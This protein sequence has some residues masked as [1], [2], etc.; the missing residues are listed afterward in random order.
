MT[1]LVFI[2]NIRLNYKSPQIAWYTNIFSY[3]SMNILFKIMD[4]AT[5][6]TNVITYY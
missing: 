2:I 4:K 6:V 5:T 3:L 1:K